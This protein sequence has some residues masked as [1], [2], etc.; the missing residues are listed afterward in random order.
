M[1]AKRYRRFDPTEIIC[2]VFDL[3]MHIVLEFENSEDVQKAIDEV[4]KC[5][6]AFHTKGLVN[7]CEASGEVPIFKIPSDLE[8][9]QDIANWMHREHPLRIRERMGMIACDEKRLAI[10]IIHGT[11]DG[12][13]CLRFVEHLCHPDE[14]WEMPKCPRSAEEEFNSQI[15]AQPKANVFCAADANLSRLLGDKKDDQATRHFGNYYFTIPLKEIRGYSP[16]NDKIHGISETMW[17][18]LLVSHAAFSKA[19]FSETNFSISTVYNLR[20][21]VSKDDV[22]LSRQN[23][24]ASLPVTSHPSENTTLKEVGDM[25]R[26]DFQQGLKEGRL[27]SHMKTVWEAVYR[28]WRNPNA[29]GIGIEMSSMGTMKI[30]GPVKDAFVTLI[31]DDK[32]DLGSVS[33]L[34]YTA[35]N[36]NKG[37]E[38]TFIGQM[39]YSSGEI[40]DEEIELF[41]KY[42]I[43]AMTK[44]DDKMTV[45]DA[46][47]ELRNLQK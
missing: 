22:D 5:S 2:N 27:F 7:W 34:T 9:L 1:F 11:G 35:E 18:S 38:K 47:N 23:Y 19:T 12:D 37:G 31:C 4:L 16:E 42:V 15:Q 20:R 8:T 24:I 3:A 33:F 28:P 39:Q 41:S 26:S 25:M 46:I 36:E 45:G 21:L 32:K 14:H 6:N 43:H 44:F 17:S 10:E 30:S 40:S 29:P 13:Y